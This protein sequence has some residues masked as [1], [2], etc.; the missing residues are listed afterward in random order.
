MSAGCFIGATTAVEQGWI[1]SDDCHHN[2]VPCVLL[3]NHPPTAR[4]HNSAVCRRQDLCSL[5]A[6]TPVCMAAP[7]MLLHIPPHALAH[8]PVHGDGFAAYLPNAQIAACAGPRQAHADRF[9]Q[10][11]WFIHSHGPCILLAGSAGMVVVRCLT[12]SILAGD[13]AGLVQEVHE[14]IPRACTCNSALGAR[15][16]ARGGVDSSV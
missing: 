6:K 4:N 13:G 8:A 16:H 10:Q 1:A 9:W 3:S 11:L 7:T 2:L 14:A 12:L 15:M 5:H